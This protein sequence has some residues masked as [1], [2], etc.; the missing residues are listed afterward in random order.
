MLLVVVPALKMVFL[1][2]ED[3]KPLP[4]SQSLESI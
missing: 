1:D 2:R 3:D 4:E